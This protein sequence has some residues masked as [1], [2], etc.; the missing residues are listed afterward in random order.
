M[1]M[2]IRSSSGPETRSGTA[3]SGGWCRCTRAGGRCK[4]RR[5]R[6][7]SPPPADARGI[8]QGGDG[9]GDGDLAVFQGLAQD[10]QDVLLELRQLV[11]EEDPVVGEAHLPGSRYLPPP[12]SP[13]SEMVWWG[14][15]KRTPDESRRG[16]RRDEPHHAVDLGGLQALLEWSWGAGWSGGGAPAWS[17][18]RPG[19]RSS[20]CCARRPRQSLKRVWHALAP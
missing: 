7:S 4:S 19:G 13:A 18:P 10:L 20:G 3:G 12:M 6:G 8:G 16:P 11:E 1:W 2:S 9:P 17:Y 15:R 5:D 14:V